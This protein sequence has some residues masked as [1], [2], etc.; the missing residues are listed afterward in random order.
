MSSDS[1]EAIRRRKEVLLQQ[2]HG[3][4]GGP[5][6]YIGLEKIRAG[7]PGANMLNELRVPFAKMW[8]PSLVPRPDDYGYH[9]DVV[10]N[11]FPPNADASKRVDS[12]LPDETPSLS[13]SMTSNAGSDGMQGRSDINGTTR[14]SSLEPGYVPDPELEEWLSL[15]GAQKPIFIGF[16]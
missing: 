2:M 15:E 3:R 10:G 11:V 9:I 12:T 5:G 16:G 13:D 4:G 8:S 1:P 7:E 6:V 14:S